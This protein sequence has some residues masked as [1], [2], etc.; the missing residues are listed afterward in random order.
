L[1]CICKA[2][3]IKGS[4][5]TKDT[6]DKLENDGRDIFLLNAVNADDMY[7][8]KYLDYGVQEEVHKGFLTSSRKPWFALENRPPAPVWVSVFNRN[9]LRFIRNEANV[10]NLTT[11]HCIY[12]N[13]FAFSLTDI[14]FA[15]L[16]TDVAKEIFEDN[17]REYGNG[18]KKFEPNDI[19]NSKV[20]DLE[21]L[22]ADAKNKILEMFH[23]YRSSELQNIARHEIMQGI[24]NI[25]L[26]HYSA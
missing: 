12:L 15:Y 23:D 22:D 18:L 9:G 8:K 17:R 25:F 2:Q 19:N 26:E 20:P 3:D 14:L 13:L 5:A 11:F 16:L 21:H 4:F 24:N 1:P 6:I 10:H 7:V